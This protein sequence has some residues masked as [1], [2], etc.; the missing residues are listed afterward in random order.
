[1]W[2]LGPR[3]HISGS[4]RPSGD[5]GPSPCPLW[6]F[7]G[8]AAARTRGPP[9]TLP[10]SV[11]RHHYNYSNV[12]FTNYKT[13]KNVWALGNDIT[14]VPRRSRRPPRHAA[15]CRCHPRP[16]DRWNIQWNMTPILMLNGL[17]TTPLSMRCCTGLSPFRILS[18][19]WTQFVSSISVWFINSSVL[20]P[21]QWGRWRGGDKC[22]LFSNFDIVIHR[23]SQCLENAANNVL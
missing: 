18:E 16:G 13:E 20:V 8:P 7:R 22:S 12:W 21:L 3:I 19:I 23:Y 17:L 2:F 5:L 10:L 4:H 14:W 9:S 11:G 15:V 1:M 6:S